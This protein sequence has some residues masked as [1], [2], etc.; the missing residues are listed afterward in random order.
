MLSDQISGACAC[1][2]AGIV[3]AAFSLKIGIL[4][5]IVCAIVW[6]ACRAPASATHPERAGRIAT[7]RSSRVASSHA[8]SQG[9]KPVAEEAM[10]LAS[11]EPPNPGEAPRFPR[12]AELKTVRFAPRAAVATLEE[13]RTL[14]TEAFR[15]NSEPNL[16]S[17]YTE[18]MR[19]IQRAIAD[20]NTTSDPAIRPIGGGTF[21][22]KP[23]IGVL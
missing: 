7:T 22:C 14:E 17:H 4:V 13:E 2:A 15:R 6:A 23:S 18:G 19:K 8:P 12:L 21:A 9:A 11:E 16:K 3:L 1:V 20:E 5:A 10:Q